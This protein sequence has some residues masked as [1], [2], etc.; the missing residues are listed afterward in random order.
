LTRSRPPQSGLVRPGWGARWGSDR[1]PQQA[2]ASELGHVSLRNRALRQS[3]SRKIPA[4]LQR[5]HEEI[6]DEHTQLVGAEYER[7]MG[8]A[9]APNEDARAWLATIGPDAGMISGSGF[10]QRVLDML[11]WT[12]KRMKALGR[13]RYTPNETLLCVR[14]AFGQVRR[15]PDSRLVGGR[16]W[17]AKRSQRRKLRGWRLLPASVN[18]RR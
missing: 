4:A 6:W 7:R 18:E 12:T 3:E 16:A 9:G 15:H 17:R 10:A 14:L 2:R 5:V 1:T 8:L 13:G 11:E